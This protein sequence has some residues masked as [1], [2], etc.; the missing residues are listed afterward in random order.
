MAGVGSRDIQKTQFNCFKQ[1]VSLSNRE[2]PE[3]QVRLQGNVLLSR[4]CLNSP[5]GQLS[6]DCDYFR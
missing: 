5:G 4:M 1:F 6:K 3:L 2:P